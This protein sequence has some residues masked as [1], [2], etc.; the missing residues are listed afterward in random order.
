MPGKEGYEACGKFGISCIVDHM[1]EDFRLVLAG[2][3]EEAG[4]DLARNLAGGASAPGAKTAP[5]PA[6]GSEP[7]DDTIRKI[8]EGK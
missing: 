7:V 1:H 4:A 3:F 8:L 2:M 6:A 5:G